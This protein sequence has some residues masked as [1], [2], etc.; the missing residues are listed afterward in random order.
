[1]VNAGTSMRAFSLSAQLCSSHAAAQTVS[2]P[3][4]LSHG[5]VNVKTP[6]CG[7]L[8]V[9][10]IS[11]D[12]KASCVAGGYWVLP[13]RVG[14]LPLACL[15]VGGVQYAW[16]L[17]LKHTHIEPR[18]LLYIGD[19]LES[20]RSILDLHYIWQHLCPPLLLS[21]LMLTSTHAHLLHTHLKILGRFFVDLY[22]FDVSNSN[23]LETD[24]SE[25]PVSAESPHHEGCTSFVCVGEDIPQILTLPQERGK[26]SKTNVQLSLTHTRWFCHSL[27][28]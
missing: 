1:M 14:F 2:I 17:A 26:A 25:I 10:W 8:S 13:R 22:Y 11:E 3:P 19:P 20:S 15:C 24:W 6:S 28:M 18:G 7:R 9:S 27:N 21:A 4:P 12:A 5:K 23:C 16:A